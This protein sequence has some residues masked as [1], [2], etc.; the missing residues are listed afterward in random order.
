[1]RIDGIDFSR[2]D[3]TVFNCV[4]HALG[5]VGTGWLRHH[6]VE[7]IRTGPEPDDLG[8]HAG[9]SRQSL[10]ESLEHDDSRTSPDHKSVSSD[11]IWARRPLGALVEFR[12]ERESKGLK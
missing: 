1:M 8:V 9:P 10:I 6:H 3:A 5:G 2:T 7:T 12:G 11:V 4:A